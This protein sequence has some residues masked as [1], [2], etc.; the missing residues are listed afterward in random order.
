VPL[1]RQ[2]VQLPGVDFVNSRFR[3]KSFRT[4]Y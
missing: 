4:N 2:A 3:P 1:L